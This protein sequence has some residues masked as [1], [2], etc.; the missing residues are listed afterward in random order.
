MTTAHPNSGTE[1]AGQPTALVILDEGKPQ[2]VLRCLVLL[3]LNFRYGLRT[4]EAA[5]FDEARKWLGSGGHDLRCVVIIQNKSVATDVGIAAFNLHDNPLFVLVPKAVAGRY[6]Q[7]M[8]RINN[9]HVVAW[10][11]AFRDSGRGLGKLMVQQLEKSGLTRP[12]DDVDGL[13]KN[14]RKAAVEHR[15]QGIDALPALPGTISRV[16]ELLADPEATAEQ[17]ERVLMLDPAIVQRLYTVA[18]SPIYAGRAGDANSLRDVIVRLGLREVAAVVMQAKLANEFLRSEDTLFDYKRFWAHSV[19]CALV[20]HKIVT[21]GL[22]P[23]PE[24]VAFH[25]YWPACLL[26]DIGKLVLGVYFW[27]HFARVMGDTVTSGNSFRAGESRTGG[28]SS[29]E[30]IGELVLTRSHLSPSITATIRQHHDLLDAPSSLSCLLHTADVISKRI[31]LSFPLE[32]E[33]QCDERVLAALNRT[34]QEIDELEQAIGDDVMTQ[35]KV[36]LKDV[37]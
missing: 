10:E 31:G 16:L 24:D 28:V 32:A 35:V 26:H 33:A 8:Q 18:S 2:T 30:E 27:D 4:I 23:L 7:Q 13:P 20:A 22:L 9:A 6:Q 11:S 36:L 37:A 21:L 1:S 12:L 29:H 15:L 14:Q 17:L 5:S 34:A 19:A 25:E 3:V